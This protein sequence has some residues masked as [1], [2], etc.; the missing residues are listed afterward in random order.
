MISYIYTGRRNGKTLKLIEMSAETGTYI[1]VSD[2]QR[3][4]NLFKYAQEN[5][6]NIP[7][8][9]TMSEMYRRQSPNTREVLVDDVED[10]L[11]K[12]FHAEIKAVTIDGDSI[13]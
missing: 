10:I 4:R 5:G 7:Y 11:R 9:V 2:H 12:Y 1:L 6:Y 8:P 13:Q 3:A